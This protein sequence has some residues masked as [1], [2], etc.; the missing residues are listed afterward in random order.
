MKRRTLKQPRVKLQT[1]QHHNVY[2]VLLGPA[3]GNIR[4]VHAENRSHKSY[5]GSAKAMHAL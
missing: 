4:K 3:A 2:V 1:A 5:S